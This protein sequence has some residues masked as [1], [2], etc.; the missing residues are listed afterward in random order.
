M[1]GVPLGVAEPFWTLR[2]C[3]IH[4][5]HAIG[6]RALGGAERFFA[7]L[8]E[9]L[10]GAGHPTTRVVRAGSALSEMLPTEASVRCGMRSG[11]D[12]LTWMAVRRLIRERRPEVVQT[13]LGRASR[14]TRVPRSSETIHIARLGGYYRPNAYR[15]ADAWVGNTGGICDHLV[16]SGFPKERVF[17]IGNFVGVAPEAEQDDTATLLRS[18]GLVDDP[19]VVFALGRF[20]ERKGFHDLIVAFAHLPAEI[21]G[22]RLVL[23]LA[24][25]GPLGPKLEAQAVQAGIGDRVRW[26]GWLNE[27]SS[28]IQAASVL[29]CPSRHEPL[30]NVILEAWAHRTPVLSTDTDGARELLHDGENGLICPPGDPATLAQRLE[31][32]LRSDP[33]DRAALIANGLTALAARHSKEAVVEHYVDLYTDRLPTLGRA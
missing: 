2:R 18:A 7:R 29:V 30:G 32:V 19:L 5:I 11:V 9:A 28:W 26:L 27:P 10:D 1:N 3:D 14:L 25:T 6:S 12:V 16:R 21:G 13:Y 15:H 4:S 24:G 22:R 31:E 23:A 33:Q 17:H 8:T 20:I